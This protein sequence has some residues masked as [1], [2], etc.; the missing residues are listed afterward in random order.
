V[1][2]P[3]HIRIDGRCQHLR[4]HANGVPLP[5]TQPQKRRWILPSG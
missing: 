2:T 3:G 1:I 4:Q 5:I